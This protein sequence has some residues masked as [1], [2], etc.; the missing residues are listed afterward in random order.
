MRLLFFASALF[1]FLTAVSSSS[2]SCNATALWQAALTYRDVHVQLAYRFTTDAGGATGLQEALDYYQNKCAL[3][4]NVA[5]FNMPACDYLNASICQAA[6]YGSVPDVLRVMDALVRYR[7]VF[8]S[9]TY[10]CPDMMQQP[11][12]DPKTGAVMCDCPPQVTCL[13]NS[14]GATSSS[15][16]FGAASSSSSSGGGGSVSSSSVDEPTSLADG[17]AWFVI[18]IQIVALLLGFIMLA[19]TLRTLNQKRRE[20]E[21]LVEL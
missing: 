15:S 13:A 1:S 5:F 19:Y 10:N 7:H 14:N 12:V 20:K 16:L 9:G 4:Q 2:S 17:T 11:L 8:V 21:T 6:L 3:G 18:G